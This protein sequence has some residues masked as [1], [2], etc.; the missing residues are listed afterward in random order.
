MIRM[1][2]D[3]NLAT[4]FSKHYARSLSFTEEAD[5]SAVT[6]LSLHVYFNFQHLQMV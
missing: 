1:D 4:F 2:I 3:T 5:S 6:L